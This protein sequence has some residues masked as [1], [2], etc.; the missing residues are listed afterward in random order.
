MRSYSVNKA[1]AAADQQ[2]G[3]LTKDLL[4]VA[5]FVVAVFSAAFL[6]IG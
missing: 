3:E 1:Q 6:F 5:A 4:F 2:P